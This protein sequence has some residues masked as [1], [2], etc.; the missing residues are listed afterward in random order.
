MSNRQELSAPAAPTPYGRPADG[1]AAPGP[2]HPG[3]AS[4]PPDWPIDWTAV[5][6][7]IKAAQGLPAAVAAG[8]REELA[9]VRSLAVGLVHTAQ[10]LVARIDRMDP[11]PGALA[12][13]VTELD[14]YR[15]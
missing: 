1:L 14:A 4:Q 13:A 3:A 10:D 15:R 8:M 2:A 7:D 9:A 12:A 6:D 5:R 11:T